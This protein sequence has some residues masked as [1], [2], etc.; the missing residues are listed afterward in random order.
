MKEHTYI[1]NRTWYEVD[2]RIRLLIA[3]IGGV[4]M[5]FIQSEFSLLIAFCV[6]ILWCVYCGRWQNAASFAVLYG[7]LFWWS[8]SLMK[9]E[10][11]SGVIIS[12][13]LFR[14]FLLIGAFLTPLASVDVGALVASMHKMHLP[15]FFIMTMAITFRFIPTLKQEYRAVRTSQKFRAIGRTLWNVIIHPITFYETLIVPLAIRIMRISDELS[16]S[17]ILRGA[18]R[19]GN[20]TCFRDVKITFLDFFVFLIFLL[21]MSFCVILNYENLM[22]AILEVLQ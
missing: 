16:A 1:K 21:V 17:A 19:K 12:V 22:N 2:P 7:L 15:R 4:L 5:L 13:I 10:E 20:G 3:I 18:D 11:V 9:Q 14:R 6:S 8:S